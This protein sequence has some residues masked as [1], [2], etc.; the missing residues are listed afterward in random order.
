MG[1]NRETFAFSFIKTFENLTS[2]FNIYDTV[3]ILKGE[4]WYNH[5]QIDF[6][7]YQSRKFYLSGY[8]GLGDFFA[9]TKTETYVNLCWYP[10]KHFNITADWTCNDVCLPQGNFTTNDIGSRIEYAFT[11]KLNN[12]IYGQWNTD[13]KEILLNY[14]INWIP[15]IGSDFHFVVNQRINTQGSKIE[16]G[17]FTL[18]AKF[19][20]RIVV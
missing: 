15:K 18:L 14:R 19:I 4:Y 1:R 17:D 2:D 11:P 7:T 13:S 9:G 12:S 6:S 10:N 16:F 3:N 8:L 20:W 5:Y